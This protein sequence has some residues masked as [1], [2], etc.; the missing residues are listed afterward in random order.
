MKAVVDNNLI[1]SGLLWGGPPSRLMEAV[2]D[3]RVELAFSLSLYAE[4]EDVLH[5]TKFAERMA[6]REATPAGVLATV[7]AVAEMVVPS[8]LAM[9]PNLRDPDDLPV[10]ECAM[11]AG[12]EAIITGDN[13]LLV[14]KEFHGIPILT[15]RAALERL[16]I[17]A[18]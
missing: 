17:S 6:R 18:E 10:L 7:M 3:G 11:A 8:P 14:L 1:V 2:R 5:R 15:A 12:A 16:G 4:L 9:P 13:D